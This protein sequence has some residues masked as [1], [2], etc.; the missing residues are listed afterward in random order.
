MNIFDPVKL[1]IEENKFLLTHLGEP[2][3]TAAKDIRPA[4][5]PNPNPKDKNPI[6]YPDGVNPAAVKPIIDRVYELNELTRHQ[7]EQWVGVEALKDRIS[8][9][10]TQAERWANDRRRGRPR[11]PSMSSFDERARPH[12]G[13]PG[14]DSGTVKTYFD[15]EGNRVPFAI[16]LVPTD[17]TDYSPE[18]VQTDKPQSGL[19]V[20][21]ELHRIECFC[22]HVEKFNP[23][24]RASFNVARGRISKHLK[25][26]TEQVD[27]H[28]EL[29]TLEFGG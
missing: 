12:L 6:F 14:S 19:K 10:L 25:S 8:T 11:F 3:I 7:G 26:A 13:A 2:W 4:R 27:S 21:A 23:E 16:E 24:S 15:Q 22:G 17:L 20:N 9:Y 28:R 18:W 29:H 5:L 1:S